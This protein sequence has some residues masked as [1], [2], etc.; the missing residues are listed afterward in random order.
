MIFYDLFF[1]FVWFIIHSGSKYVGEMQ[2]N[3]ETASKCIYL[4]VLPSNER[5]NEREGRTKKKCFE[6]SKKKN[7]K[8][9]HFMK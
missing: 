1:A 6:S 5:I 9:A 4:F 8:R 7:A 2:F 3:I